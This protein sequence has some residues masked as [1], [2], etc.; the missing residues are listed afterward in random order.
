ME[1]AVYFT[2]VEL[3]RNTD[4]AL[5]HVSFRD[6]PEY[7]MGLVYPD[8]N[9]ME[10][11]MQL[12][13]LERL[14]AARNVTGPPSRLYFGQEFCEY[15]IPERSDVEHAYYASR[16]LGWEFTYVTGYLTDAGLMRT[17][18]NLEFL[19]ETAAGTEVVANDW[20]LLSVLARDFP[21]LVPILGRLLV[22]LLRLA[23]YSVDPPPMCRRD[24]V[25]SAEEIR[26]R[27]FES[28]R[29][30]NL[31]IARYREELQRLG[32]RRVDVDM[33]PQGLEVSQ[34][35]RA[36]LRFSCYY[37]WAYVSGGRNCM[38]AAL[39]DPRR[40]YLV[41]DEPCPLLCRQLNRTAANLGFPEVTLQR[42]NSVFQFRGGDYAAQYFDGLCP[43]DRLV[44][45][46]Y[47][48][49]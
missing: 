41:L 27:Q 29:R 23:R 45:E 28:L 33:V 26:G 16:Q 34:E 32:I 19:A 15:L 43:V 3:V 2:S 49:V 10:Y 7:F 17:R 1:L 8:A 18:R 37:P 20:G 44:F 12:M 5:R 36:E 35:A 14:Q 38:T 25:A 13:A 24:I 42:G 40:K 46:P 30:T 47:L 4:E 21:D 39:A 48:P 22:K 11:A 31:S 6:L 9:S